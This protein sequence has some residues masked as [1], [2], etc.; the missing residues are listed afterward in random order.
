MT[1]EVTI[2]TIG[3]DEVVKRCK[4]ACWAC[5]EDVD[6]QLYDYDVGDEDKSQRFPKFM[7][8]TEMY[9]IIDDIVTKMIEKANKGIEDVAKEI[10]GHDEGE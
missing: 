4:E 10:L 8:G 6:L 7:K 1:K 5:L 9:T 2:Q 3:F